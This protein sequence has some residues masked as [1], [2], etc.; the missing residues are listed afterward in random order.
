LL[1]DGKVQAFAISAY[2]YSFNNPVNLKDETGAWPTPDTILDLAFVAYSAYDVASTALSG[3]EVSGTQ[4]AALQLALAA[5][6]FRLQQ[7]EVQRYMRL[8]RRMT[9]FILAPMVIL[10]L[11]R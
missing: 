11:R 3:E 6:C 2:N 10:P 5:Y 4:R 7:V 8:Q 9:L 1:K